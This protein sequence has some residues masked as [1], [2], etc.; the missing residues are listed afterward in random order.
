[1]ASQSSVVA[2]NDVP[3]L[4]AFN[5]DSFSVRTINR[6]GEIWFVANDVCAA[7]EVANPRDAISRLDEDERS[8]VAIT[9]TRSKG[10]ATQRREVTVINESGLYSLI[11]TSRKPEAK[12]FKRWVTHEVLPAIRKTG[13]YHHTAEFE[14]RPLGDV[15][16][17]IVRSHGQFI[18][19]YITRHGEVSRAVN[20]MVRQHFNVR[21]ASELTTAQLPELLSLLETWGDHAYRLW[22]VLFQ[23]ET[24]ALKQPRKPYRELYPAWLVAEMEKIAVPDHPDCVKH[25]V[26][27]EL[28]DWARCRLQRH[29]S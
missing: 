10:S 20:G 27:K 15:G 28:P 21:H 13:S 25:T 1:M 14:D 9:D 16:E 11:L 7:L 3:S 17:Y 23:L 18:A 2:S 29:A 24:T 12:R 4:H 26:R 19:C 6:D 8:A 5:F 22:R